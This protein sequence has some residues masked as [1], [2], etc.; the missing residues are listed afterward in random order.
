MSS[1]ARRAS[2]PLGVVLLRPKR[3]NDACDADKPFTIQTLA[4]IPTSAELAGLPL[5]KQRVAR[6]NPTRNSSHDTGRKWEHRD[7]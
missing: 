1:S 3:C 5:H 7:S 6:S 2:S 4:G